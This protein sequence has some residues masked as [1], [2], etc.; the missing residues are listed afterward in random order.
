MGLTMTNFLQKFFEELFSGIDPVLIA[1]SLRTAIVAWW[2]TVGSFL[3]DALLDYLIQKLSGTS[4]PPPARVA[5]AA[6]ISGGVN[7]FIKPH[8]TTQRHEPEA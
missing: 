8:P 5:F 2:S 1:R 4:L 7:Y 6:A 3:G